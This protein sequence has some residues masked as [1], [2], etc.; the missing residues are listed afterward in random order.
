MSAPEERR[1][2]IRTVEG[3]MD[4]MHDAG[5]FPDEQ[6]PD[7][8]I[9]HS[10]GYGCWFI[11]LDGEKHGTFGLTAEQIVD[12]IEARA[13]WTQ[14]EIDEIKAVAKDRAKRYAADREGA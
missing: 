8:I 12:R 5:R 1:V 9:P 2:M 13:R 3:V 11:D 4:L 6:R 10:N 7:T 14:Q